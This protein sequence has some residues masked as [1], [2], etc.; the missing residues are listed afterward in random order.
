MN[1]FEKFLR[2]NGYTI[3]DFKVMEADEQD[4]LQNQYL[5]EIMERTSI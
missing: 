4:E 1:P 5:T 2:N 3:A